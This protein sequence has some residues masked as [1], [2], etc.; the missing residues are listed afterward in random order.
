MTEYAA[1][2]CALTPAIAMVWVVAPETTEPPGCG[3]SESVERLRSH[4]YVRGVAPTT[5]VLNDAAAPVYAPAS[6]GWV[7]NWV[8]ATGPTRA[9]LAEERP[10]ARLRLPPAKREGGRGPGPSSSNCMPARA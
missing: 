1:A 2:S 5:V 3:P 9:I 6:A 10:P 7:M 8:S 4:W